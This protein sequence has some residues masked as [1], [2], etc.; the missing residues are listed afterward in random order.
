MPPEATQPLLANYGHVADE[1]MP[2][3]NQS[4]D[5]H[6]VVGVSK[7]SVLR[8]YAKNHNAQDLPTCPPVGR[9]W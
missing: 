5:Y 9:R 7:D 3:Q 8:R 4:S 2:T 6:P 1:S